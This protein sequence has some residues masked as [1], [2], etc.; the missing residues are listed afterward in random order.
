MAASPLQVWAALV[1]PEA[2]ARWKVPAGMSAVV[3]EYDVRVGGRLRVSLTYDD[4]GRVGKSSP[5]TDAYSGHFVQLVPGE[6][7]VEV[8]EFETADPALQGE[9][10]S[11][12]RLSPVEEGT[13]VE[14]VHEGLP[15]GVPPEQN[16]QGWS[17]SLDRLAALVEER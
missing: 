3:H 11:T 14:A 1:D 15:H 7:V 4:G 8:D 17:E 16:E 2:V 13:L 9:M 5:H 12:I 10:T 6:L